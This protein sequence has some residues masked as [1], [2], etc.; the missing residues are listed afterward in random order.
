MEPQSLI[1]GGRTTTRAGLSS[2]VSL[3]PGGQNTCYSLLCVRCVMMEV[4]G[5][6]VI[7]RRWVFPAR[8]FL[9]IFGSPVA[10]K[11]PDLATTR[12]G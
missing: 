10:A 7:R 11:R 12:S 3:R 5:W 6:I 4:V 8:R 9:V 2:G 1:V